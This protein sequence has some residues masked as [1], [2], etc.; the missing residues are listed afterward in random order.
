MGVRLAQSAVF[1]MGRAC[2]TASSD[3]CVCVYGYTRCCED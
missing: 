1:L 3:M 2:G